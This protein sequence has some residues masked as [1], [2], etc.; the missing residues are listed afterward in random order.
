[1][2]STPNFIRHLLDF[3]VQSDLDNDLRPSHISLYLTLFR[4][5]NDFHFQ[6]PFR[7]NLK[8]IMQ[9]SKIGTKTCFRKS[10]HELEE[11][12]YIRHFKPENPG[13][14]TM[15]SI[16]GFPCFE[17]VLNTIRDEM[18]EMDEKCDRNV[19]DFEPKPTHI[20]QIQTEIQINKEISTPTALAVAAFFTSM[21]YPE[22][23]AKKFF[24]HYEANGWLQN[25][26]VPI[27][28]WKAAADK[29]MLN[30]KFPNKRNDDYPTSQ[31]YGTPL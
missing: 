25:G 1:M 31:N 7:I 16:M 29:W 26:K 4:W 5:W 12:G 11:W 28:N 6:N 24:A 2:K 20:K 9:A 21:S 22:S 3:F 18:D 8:L 19:A 14:F 17:G 13:D 10:L 27:T 23:E 15:I 30:V